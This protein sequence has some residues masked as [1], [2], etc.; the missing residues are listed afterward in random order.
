MGRDVEASD[1]VGLARQYRARF[2]TTTMMGAL[3]VSG[4][5][6]QGRRIFIVVA[7]SV[8]DEGLGLTTSSGAPKRARDRG[9]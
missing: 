2:A 4:V 1:E 5:R 3:R 6:G 9:R 8:W 7:F